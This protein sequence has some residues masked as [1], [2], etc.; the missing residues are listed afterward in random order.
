MLLS[1][2]TNVRKRKDILGEFLNDVCDDIKKLHS[3]VSKKNFDKLKNKTLKK[4]RSNGLEE[5]A[6]YLT[7]QWLDGVFN[8]WQI[9]CTPPGYSTTNN[10][11][12]SHN[13]R[14][15]FH[16]TQ[17][18]K[19]NILP[20]LNMFSDVFRSYEATRQPYNNYEKISQSLKAKG[21][22]LVDNRS[23]LLIKKQENY[24]TYKS[25][26]KQIYE[27]KLNPLKCSC[28]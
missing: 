10:P 7:K 24:F 13:S 25:E 22:D 12:E 2:S 19:M 6:E 4:W 17:R 18:F 28:V 11:V 3:S 21:Q 1:C 23:D 16:F 27:I 9:F 26:S 5:F 8:N 20:L 14:I 15:K